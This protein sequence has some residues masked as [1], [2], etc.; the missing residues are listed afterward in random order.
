MDRH[1]ELLGSM[2][3]QLEGQRESIERLERAVAD[4]LRRA[5]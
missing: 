2:V 5:P 4:A 3:R 1:G